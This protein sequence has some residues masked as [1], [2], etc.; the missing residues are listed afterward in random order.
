MKFEDLDINKTYTYSD[1]LTWRFEEMVELIKGKVFKMS[2]APSSSHQEI[3]SNLI[4]VIGNYLYKKS[5]K[6]YHAP[7]DVRLTTTQFQSNDEIFTVVQPDISIVCD[8]SKVDAQG[9]LG[10][11]EWVIEILSPSTKRKDIN[12]KLELYQ[13]NGVSVY[14]IIHP[15]DQTVLAYSNNENNEFQKS[16][17][18]DSS[19]KIKIELF[20]DF[21]IDLKDIFD[22]LTN[23]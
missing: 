1:Y 11:P 12:E 7:F 8:L 16:T 18:Y 4:R 5:C 20:S 19:Q 21:E 17:L 15:N 13:E 22:N 10:A 6:V 9:C 2:P 23:S 14:W 3:S